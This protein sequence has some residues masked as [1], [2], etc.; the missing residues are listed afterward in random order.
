MP[1]LTD[2][3]FAEIER[4]GNAAIHEIVFALQHLGQDDYDD[5]L[6]C[7]V[8]VLQ[9]CETIADSILAAQPKDEQ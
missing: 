9:N 1:A 5:A 6:T 2:A 8:Q 7:L 4:L 3:Q